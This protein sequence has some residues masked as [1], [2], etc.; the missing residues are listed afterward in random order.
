MRRQETLIALLALMASASGA[1]AV[2][3]APGLAADKRPA[4]LRGVG[5]DQHLGES[6]PLELRFRDES[7]KVVRLG[8]YFGTKPVLLS[9]N[10]YH[11]PM[12][13]PLLLEGLVRS[14]RPLSWN[15][16]DEFRIL[17]VSIDPRETPAVAAEKKRKMLEQYSRPRAAEGWQFLTG[18]R[19]SIE[20]LAEAVGFHYGYDAA[21]DQFAH[22]AALMVLTPDGRLSRYLYGVDPMPRDVRLAL[23]EASGNKIGTLAD[24]LLLFCY[25]Y[26]PATGT[27]GAATMLALRLAAIM[28]VLGLGAFVFSQWRRETLKPQT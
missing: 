28:T 4:A 1:R 25:H 6:L 16:G 19:E 12:L 11:C 23:V 2:A 21:S 7:G 27:Y 13:C 10:Y 15:A 20:R 3:E 17:T 24:Q 18:D 5:V 14:L 9:L 26:D 22:A 8:D